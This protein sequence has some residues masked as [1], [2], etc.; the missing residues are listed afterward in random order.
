MLN[1]TGSEDM[2]MLKLLNKV[3]VDISKCTNENFKSDSKIFW[4]LVNINNATSEKMNVYKVDLNSAYWAVALQQGVISKETDEYYRTNTMFMTDKIRK[5]YRVKALGMLAT[6]KTTQVY[7]NNILV[8]E[9]TKSA[10][11][12]D[13]YISICEQVDIL[14]RRYLSKA[15]YYYFDCLFIEDQNTAYEVMNEIRTVYGIDSKLKPDMIYLNFSNIYSFIYSDDI[16]GVYPADLTRQAIEY[17]NKK[18]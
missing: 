10:E 5:S 17:L 18:E 15:V 11:T 6:K 4:Y 3:K 16:Q 8:H 9:E 2:F 13:I 1:D 12:K 14:M 7:E